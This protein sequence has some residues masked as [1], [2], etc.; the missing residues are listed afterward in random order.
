MHVLRGVDH[1]TLCRWWQSH[2]LFHVMVLP[3]SCNSI[4]S[5]FVEKST[6][7]TACMKSL[8]EI[9]HQHLQY[10]AVNKAGLHSNFMFFKGVYRRHATF[11]LSLFL[12][13]LP[14]A[15]PIFSSTL[16]HL[17]RYFTYHF[18]SHTPLFFKGVFR[19]HEI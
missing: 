14:S 8:A 10:P 4:M 6:V 12:P 2:E 19:R 16:P 5:N 9:E 3:G 15:F 13:L 11:L 18:P 7:G 17:L 1:P